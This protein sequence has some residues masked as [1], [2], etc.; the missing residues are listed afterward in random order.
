MKI[1]RRGFLQSLA[2]LGV[3]GAIAPETLL[4]AEPGA[5]PVDVIMN[6]YTRSKTL[7]MLI[8]QWYI[9]YQYRPAPESPEYQWL[10]F[11]ADTIDERKA[12]INAMAS[13]MNFD[14][15]IGAQLDSFA[16]LNRV[17]R[18]LGESDEN[19]RRRTLEKV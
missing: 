11:I 19:L 5:V 6:V 10:S 18:R 13:A 16:K 3:L 14:T 7:E 17:T 9:V 12:F 1:G 4:E 15:A 8:D 2:A